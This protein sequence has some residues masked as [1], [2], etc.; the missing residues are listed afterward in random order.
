MT[1]SGICILGSTGSIGQ[2]TLE[3]IKLHPNI[4]K[5]I[6]LSAQ[7]SVDKLFEQCCYFKPVF[8]V[9]ANKE[10]AKK[11]RTKIQ[12]SLLDV[13]VLDGLEGLCT[14]AQLPSVHKVVAAIVGAAGLLPLMS[15]VEAGKQI[16]LA[17]KEPLVMAG[18]LLLAKAKQ[19]QAILL[20]VD[21]EHNALF[22]CMPD[23]Y[24]T[25]TRP[26]GVHKLIL[27]AS[28]GP[29]LHTATRELKAV[30]PQMAV[31]HPN[32]KMGEKIT[33]D[34]A[35]LMNKGLEVIEACKLFQFSPDEVEVVIHPQSIIHSLVEYV[36]GSV[37]A[38]LGTPDM[39][40]PIT[41]CLSWPNR[42][43]S[44][45]KRLS[46]TEI[47]QLTFLSPDKDKFRCLPLS[48]EAISLG[49]AAPTVLNASNEVAVQAFLQSRMRFTEIPVIIE[50]ILNKLYNLSA[51][52][53]EEILWADKVAREQALALINTGIY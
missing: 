52:T 21:S 23:G 17:N 10:A 14:I 44:G 22:Q 3:V 47:G 26:K 49:N 50:K 12:A 42:L 24:V 36:D 38:Q 7:N 35:T 33:I 1:I 15:A 11:L 4:F 6:A 13:T 34:C 16:L 40:V 8:A 9:M 32:W 46:L 19:S 51:A 5:V 18:D 39:R 43:R 2:S 25:G 53:M 31:K 30:T 28:G 41:H 37:L 29:F 48:I 45:A 20:P 27:T